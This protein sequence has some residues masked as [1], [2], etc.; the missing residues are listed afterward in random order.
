MDRTE[1]NINELIN[2]NLKK[3]YE[4]YHKEEYYTYFVDE[5]GEILNNNV[6]DP[7]TIAFEMKENGLIWMNG[8]SCK[9]KSK[10]AEI[11]R[12]GG[13]LKYLEKEKINDLAPKTINVYGD[14]NGFINQESDFKKAHLINKRKTSNN[15]PLQKSLIQKIL[16]NPWLILIVGAVISALLSADRVMGFI[17]NYINTI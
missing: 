15:I 9:L 16:S 1:I 2:I 17:N 7:K 14:N 10:G 5:K 8:E 4:S 13:W 11:G 3:I 6:I 12:N